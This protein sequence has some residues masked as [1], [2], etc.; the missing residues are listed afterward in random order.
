MAFRLRDPSLATSE[1][2][3]DKLERLI[4]DN[5]EA[6]E[7]AGLVKRHREARVGRDVTAEL[8]NAMAA[9]SVLSVNSATPVFLILDDLEH[10]RRIFT[11]GEGPV[12]TT[13]LT[14]ALDSG[15]FSFI[16]SARTGSALTG[17]FIN[18]YLETVELTGLAEDDSVSMLME[19]SRQYGIDTDSEI[20]VQAA[21]KLERNPMYLKNL[22]WAAHR[23]G[24]D[25]TELRDLSD[26][27]A[28]ELVA[29]NTGF[30]LRGAI[31]L[32][33]LNDLRVL[34]ALSSAVGTTSEE[35][36]AER[37]RFGDRE[38][39]GMINRLASQGLLV[40]TLGSIKWAGDGVMRDFIHYMYETRLK[41]KSPEE[42]KTL[43]VRD[44]L[45]EGF[46][47]RGTEVKGRFKEE[48]TRLAGS[49]DGVRVGKV[50]FDNLSFVSKYKDGVFKEGEGGEGGGSEEIKLPRVVGCFDAK[51]WES[52]EAGPP[53]VIAHGFQN[54]RYDAGNEVAWLICVKEAVTPANVGD[55][56]NFLRRAAFLRDNFR[57]TRVVG[58]MVARE[59]FTDEAANMLS[60]EGVFS[61]D[62]IQLGI[63]RGSLRAEP[64]GGRKG[65]V[66]SPASEFEIVLPGSGK[67]ELVAARAAEEIGT[68]MGFDDTSIG[69][70]RAALVEACIN[71][72]EHGRTKAGKVHLKFIASREGLTIN[73]QNSGADFDA[74]A[75]KRQASGTPRMPAKRGWGI[76]LMKGLMD[77]VRFERLPEGSRI[78]LVKYLT[79]K[80]ARGD[81]NE[82]QEL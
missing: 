14:E 68:E 71:A 60:R 81:D 39:T 20:L 17:G 56:E 65:R 82:P 58:W 10:A 16:A 37:F 26:L 27:Y 77:E 2:S 67:S 40:N 64:A 7:L 25:I 15:T 1:L 74:S 22:V 78:V 75:L 32:K 30:A 24:R 48:V 73:V 21:R 18:G 69:Q 34:H 44:M 47:R 35:E 3:L 79:K 41:G 55:A 6:Q 29:G 66:L 63:L 36:L 53:V 13:E 59:G 9:P 72:F 57:S 45:K 4:E 5:A 12:V 46:A 50:L 70:I 8:R 11:A 33:G 23:G 43:L 28:Q 42:V 76:E 62:S 80:G 38:L 19:L 54:D 49:F 61:S 31:R 51:R 52:G